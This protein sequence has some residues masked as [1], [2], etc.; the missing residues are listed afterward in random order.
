MEPAKQQR[1]GSCDVRWE[2]LDT[3][4]V[5]I[6]STGP[7]IRERLE[8]QRVVQSQF[9]LLGFIRQGSW[10]DIMEKA[11][12]LKDSGQVQI[13][14]NSRNIVTATVVGDHG[15]YQCEFSRDD[16]LSWAITGWQCECPWDQYAWGRTRQWKK[17]EGRVCAHV[18][19]AFWYARSQT[20]D[21][22]IAPGGPDMPGGMKGPSPEA[23]GQGQLFNPTP[24]DLAAQQG[25]EPSESAPGAAPA[26]VG[27]PEGAPDAT[28]A[29]PGDAGVIPPQ[30]MLPGMEE[31]APPPYV[32][33]TAPSGTT[34]PPDAVSV[35]GARMPSPQNPL[36]QQFVFSRTAWFG[37]KPKT[38]YAN[39]LRYTEADERR[40]QLW[41]DA[42]A[43][44]LDPRN[45]VRTA[46]DKLHAIGTLHPSMRAEP[47][48]GTPADAKAAYTR[49]VWRAA[50]ATTGP[51][52]PSYCPSRPR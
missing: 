46:D 33:G 15:T 2:R 18:L 11:K 5:R 25:G 37:R 9:E 6:S 3:G 40:H 21:E 17:Y 34:A 43:Q 12:R 27:G 20:L 52:R 10:A 45:V 50:R 4:Q 38:E 19:A 26:P 16:P 35:P 41:D 44:G 31:P 48:G 23:M 7:T 32:P 36:Q 13:G 39:Y 42:Y 24:L 29:P 1:V 49:M 22:D 51:R 28:S 30:P 47:W 14:N 8:A